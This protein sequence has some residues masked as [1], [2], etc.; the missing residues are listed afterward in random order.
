[1]QAERRD[2]GGVG[3][4]ENAEHAAFLAQPVVVQIEVVGGVRGH[5]AHRL[6]GF[7]STRPLP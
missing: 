1:M 3:M 7:I 2:G 6:S 4:P 5:L